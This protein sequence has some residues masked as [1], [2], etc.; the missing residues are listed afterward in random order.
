MK[1]DVGYSIVNTAADAENRQEKQ[2]R[3][4]CANIVGMSD[5]EEFKHFCSE[6]R[7]SMTQQLELAGKVLGQCYNIQFARQLLLHAK[8]VKQMLEEGRSLLAEEKVPRHDVMAT[9]ATQGRTSGPEPGVRRPIERF[10]LT[11]FGAGK[12]ADAWGVMLE[13]M[14]VLGHLQAG[15]IEDYKCFFGVKRRKG[16]DPGLARPLMFYSDKKVLAFWIAMMYGTLRYDVPYDVVTRGRRVRKG[17]Y[18]CE[19]L[20]TTSGGR[21][22]DSFGRTRDPYW[23]VVQ[24]GICVNKLQQRGNVLAKH[25][26]TTALNPPLTLTPA[27]EIIS[28]LMPLG[29]ELEKN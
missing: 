17:S 24:N 3:D 14:S 21:G 28:L 8:E 1:S 6:N 5:I 16:R 27:A 18:R 29:C 26:F 10:S 9:P 20:I 25:S 4:V 15:D 11:P 23:Q 19:P 22:V 12:D 13:G 7:I 2:E